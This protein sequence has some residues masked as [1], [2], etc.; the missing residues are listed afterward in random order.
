MLSGHEEKV[1]LLWEAYKQKLGTSKFSHIYFDL[2][3]LL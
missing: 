2:N 1:E 3:T